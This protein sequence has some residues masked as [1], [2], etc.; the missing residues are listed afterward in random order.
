[1]WKAKIMNFTVHD[2]CQTFARRLVTV[3]VDL[4]PVKAL[5]GHRDISMSIR[6]THLSSDR[7]QTAVGKL[8]QVAAN[9]PAIFITASTSR[10]LDY[11]QPL[12]NTHAPVAQPG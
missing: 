5:L 12:E 4:P 1:V 2:L 6:Y 11:S 7:Q 3:G 8:E 10:S 9:V